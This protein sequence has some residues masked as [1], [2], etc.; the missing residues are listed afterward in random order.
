MSARRR[1]RTQRPATTFQTH[2]IKDSAHDQEPDLFDVALSALDLEK[3]DSWIVDSGAARH[4]TGNQDL[5]SDVQRHKTP[6]SN[7]QSATPMVPIS[8]YCTI[9]IRHTI[10]KNWI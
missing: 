9:R 6:C 1:N 10:R 2:L 3:A 7:L 5:L 4:V 8:A